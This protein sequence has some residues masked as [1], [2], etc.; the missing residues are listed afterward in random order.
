MTMRVRFTVEYDIVNP[1]AFAALANAQRILQDID[2]DPTGDPG[3]AFMEL[4]GFQLSDFGD[5][6]KDSGTPIQQRA[7]DMI[8][9]ISRGCVAV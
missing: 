5:N 4:Y 1:A 7:L 9:L 2:V 3:Y 6:I 8:V